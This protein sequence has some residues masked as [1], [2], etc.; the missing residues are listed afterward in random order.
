MQAVIVSGGP[1]ES[2]PFSVS[3][4]SQHMLDD[5]LFVWSHLFVE[6]VGFGFGDVFAGVLFYLHAVATSHQTLT[7]LLDQL[8]S[9]MLLVFSCG[10]N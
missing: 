7:Y 9:L 1:P 6:V 8:F 4:M 5:F 10:G 3:G 2:I